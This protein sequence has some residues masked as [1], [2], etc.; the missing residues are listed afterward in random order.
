M[1]PLPQFGAPALVG[2]EPVP[3]APRPVG[4]AA[5]IAAFGL[6]VPSPDELVAIGERHTY[7]RDGRWRV[8]TP[9][10]RPKDTNAAHL[11]FALRH[12]G[13]DLGVLSALFRVM[14]PQVIEQWVRSEPTGQYARA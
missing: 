13:V 6:E 9:R 12:E 8:L 4:Y 10:Y 3:K 1:E 14:S 7:R 2:E 5:L 11:D